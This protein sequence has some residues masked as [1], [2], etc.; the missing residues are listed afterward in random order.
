LPPE[1]KRVVVLAEP[2]TLFLPNFVARLAEL[3][4]L[5]AIVEVPGRPLRASLEKARAAFG[6]AGVA[7]LG[8]SEVA[9]RV[10]DRVSPRRFYSLA[11]V[12]RRLGIPHV[13]VPDLHGPECYEALERFRPDVVFAQVNKLVRPELLQRATFWNKHCS[14]LPRHAGVFPVFWALLEGDREL[15][16]TVHVM[17]EEFDGGEILQQAAIPAAGQ[18]FFGG[19]HA[20]YDLAAPLLAAALRGE[21]EAPDRSGVEGS[22]VGFPT[23]QDRAAFRARGARLGRPFRLHAPVSLSEER[24]A[25]APV[26]S[27]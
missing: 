13:R 19:Y 17:N 9:A 4:P 2:E 3:H 16:V 20:L 18:T 6:P 5:V 27:S 10:V 8:A 21:G 12:A 25:A 26:A 22:Y 14:L 1:P 24:Y 7:A 11:K 23:P 15:G